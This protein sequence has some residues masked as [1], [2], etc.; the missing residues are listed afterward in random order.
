MS[1]F[2]SK[3]R[4]SM[5]ARRKQVAMSVAPATISIDTSSYASPAR[6]G[7]EKDMFLLEAA[8]AADRIIVTRDESLR[9]ALKQ[10]RDGMKLLQ[11]I[12]WINPETDG[13]EAM[14]AL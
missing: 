3:W 4:H 11:S 2:S 1:K 12:R 10:R 13:P 9:S 8:L 14:E 6:E 5:A 7:I